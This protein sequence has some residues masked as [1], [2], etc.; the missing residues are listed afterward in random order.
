MAET[1][2]SPDKLSVRLGRGYIEAANLALEKAGY[3][4][5]ANFPL[6]KALLLAAI[7][8]RLKKGTRS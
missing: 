2:N 1:A 5:A 6:E 8:G 7:A 3:I 4:E